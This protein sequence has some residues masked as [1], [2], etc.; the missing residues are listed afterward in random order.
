ME[1]RRKAHMRH[2]LLPLT[3]GRRAMVSIPGRLL[4]KT[5]MVV[6]RRRKHPMVV[7]RRKGIRMDLRRKGLTATHRKVLTA[8]LRRPMVLT[9]RRKAHRG[10]RRRSG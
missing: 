3:H 6:R 1:R 10:H 5:P 4:I 8:M 9:A 2:R 7:R